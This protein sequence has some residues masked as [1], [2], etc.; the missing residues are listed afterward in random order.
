MKYA[1][2]GGVWG[3]SPESGELLCFENGCFLEPGKELE[4]VFLKSQ[5]LVYL[6]MAK[7]SRRSSRVDG[8]G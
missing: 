8:A 1:A 2:L 4:R 3:I 7:Y 6:Q 5:V